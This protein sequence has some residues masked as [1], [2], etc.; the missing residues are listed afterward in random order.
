METIRLIGRSS[1][2]SL[3]QIDIA[4]QLIEQHFPEIKVTVIARSSKGDA[5]QEIPLHTVE[6]SDFFTKD[7]FDA[8]QSGEADIAVHSLKDMSSAH[9]FG[10][11]LFA[12]IDREDTRDVVIFNN[13][14]EKKIKNG[15]PIVIGT[16]S[17]RREAM[18]TV[19][20]KKA[21]PQLNNNINITT[22]PIRGNVETRLKKLDSG[23]YDATI[24]ATAGLNRL[25]KSE[26]NAV[27]EGV[28]VK[29]LLANKKLMLLPLIEC[30]PAPCQGA[31]VAEANPA[32]KKASA[33]L[34]AINNPQLFA[35]CYA[36]RIEAIKY[37]TGCI[38]KFGVTT[39]TTQHGLSFYASGTDAEGTQFTH[40]APAPEL[41]L[42]PQQ[43]FS[44]TDVMKKFFSYEWETAADLATNA[45]VIFVSNY[46]AITNSSAHLLQ[47]KGATQ[48]LLNSELKAGNQK[49]I[50]AAGTRT[51][52]EL[53]KQGFWVSG[54]GDGLGFEFLLPSLA[55]PLLQII[56][57]DICII[58]NT[59]AARRWQQKGYTAI[60][61]YELKTNN[62]TTI[63]E[64]IK[65][66]PAIFWSS[67]AQFE[68]Y[69]SY[70]NTAAIHL[71]AGG[72]TASLLKTSGVEPIIFPTIKSFELWRNSF[73]R[74]HNVV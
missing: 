11:N 25:L 48:Q 14:I 70:A 7:I 28:T 62:D 1:R 66:A 3:L 8:L 57:N 27:I 31:I 50:F 40:W 49:I 73:T 46:K 47:H 51:W 12:V 35:D 16:C 13:N 71:C 67:Y 5:L 74:L 41:T 19:F 52:Y 37:G 65:K 23:A 4:K 56:S 36:E 22:T 53:A 26:S 54:C 69:G 10:T 63:I 29:Q 72:E 21:L 42:L 34:N 39:L 58:T 59:A 15:E 68:C 64:N 61:N 9:F 18:A 24:L 33:I 32:N 55:M 44:S 6:G 30:V 38:Q 43:V 17:P 45:P 60:S 20:L 2:L